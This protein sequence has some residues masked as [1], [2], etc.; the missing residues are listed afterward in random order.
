VSAASG[1]GLPVF[2]TC[3]SGPSRAAAIAPGWVSFPATA[4]TPAALAARAAA[5]VRAL[6]AAGPAPVWVC[7]PGRAAPVGLAPARRWVSCGSGSWAECALAAGLGVGVVLF[8]PPAVAPP[9]GWGFAPVASGLFAGG[10]FL[11]P[12]SR[13]F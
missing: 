5:C 11:P 2:A 9:A 13:L 7:W 4:A 12:V 1:L 6:A 10:F 8:L 3:A